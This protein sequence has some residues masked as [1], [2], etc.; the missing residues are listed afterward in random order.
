MP[1]TLYRLTPVATPPPT[2]DAGEYLIT[3]NGEPALHV[4]LWKPLELRALA[5]MVDRVA[6]HPSPSRSALS[7]RARSQSPIDNPSASIRNFG[8]GSPS[9]IQPGFKSGSAS[10]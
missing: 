8:S 6:D 3:R 4:R 7:A 5:D 9:K 1:F 10:Q 2:L